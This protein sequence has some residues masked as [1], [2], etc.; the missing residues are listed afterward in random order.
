MLLTDPRFGA[1]LVTSTGKVLP[2]DAVEC[3]AAYLENETVSEEDVHSLWVTDMLAPDSLIELEEAVFLRSETISSPMGL[4][5]AAFSNARSPSALIDRFGGELLSWNEVRELVREEQFSST[6]EHAPNAGP[7]AAAS[8]PSVD[9]EGI[10]EVRPGPEARS[11][12]R[13]IDAAQPGS[14]VRIHPGTYRTDTTIVIRTR[15]TVE[16]VDAPV[17]DAGGNHEIIRVEADSVTIRGLTLRNVGVSFVDDRAAIRYDGV[18]GGRIEA[19]RIEDGFFGIYLAN[20][21]GVTVRGNELTAHAE[22]ETLA[23]NGIHLWHCKDITIAENRV[24]GHRDGIY[25]EFV[26]DSRIVGNESRANL[27]YGLHFM[28]SDRCRYANNRFLENDAGVAVMYTQEVEMVNNDFADNWGGASYGLLLKDIT[29]SRIVGNRFYRNTTGI[30]SENSSR[31]EI[32]ANRFQENGWA[33]R[34][35]ANSL[36][37]RYVRNNFVGNTFDVATNSRRT[38]GHFARNYWDA[39]QGYDL[40]RDGY[41]DVAF[42]PVRLF[43]LIVEQHEPALVLLRSLFVD[44][45]DAAERMIPILTPEMLVDRSPRME[46]HPL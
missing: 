9:E 24:V 39:Y 44:L 27:R 11:I 34:L 28:F 32:R 12:Q 40:D 25:F 8:S 5:L 14:T 37:N 3:M 18:L 23:G 41:G 2:F 29:D 45:L 1:E 30:Y 42:H 46:P 20:T 36:E 26:E 31:L 19:N 4:Q 15:L 6:H 35:M 10:V 17:L 7:D 13:A 16:G 43:S 21:G 38:S 33:V 22:R